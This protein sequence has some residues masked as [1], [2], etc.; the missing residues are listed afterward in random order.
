MRFSD[1]QALDKVVQAGSF[2]AAA[3][4]LGTDKARLSR[5]V[6]ALERELGTRLLE[7]STRALRL[8]ET[9]REVLERARGILAAADDLERFARSLNNEP[10]GTLRL[11]CTTDFA[12][13]A[14]NRWITGYLQRW[15]QVAVDVDFTPRL[16]DL[17]HEG[18]DLALRVG[19]LED[20]T[21][22]ARRLGAMAY[23]LFASPRYLARAG[24]PHDLDALRGHELLMFATG[25]GRSG[26]E[27]QDA[28][29]PQA[30]PLRVD[31]P[32]RVRSGSV[33]LLVQACMSGLGIARLPLAVAA[34]LP[35]GQLQ[36]VLQRWTPV[37]VAVHA[38]FPSSRYLAPKVRAFIDH[39]VEHFGLDDRPAQAC[40]PGAAPAAAARRAGQAKRKLTT[41]SGP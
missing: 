26:W 21:L 12:L 25:A 16:V 2:T 5:T 20:S 15:P 41:P 14:A 9:G 35:P 28:A 4:L 31:G 36:P 33:T 39:A 37:P 17:V 40:A 30:R 29:E 34:T 38:V 10:R 13:I 8:T 11:S 18:F 32:T 6:S 1:L 3:G 27:L 24:L 19:V 7:R 22:T 23:G